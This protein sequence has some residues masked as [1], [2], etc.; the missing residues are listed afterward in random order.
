M[1]IIFYIYIY[2]ECVF[3]IL[4]RICIYTY[5][6]YVYKNMYISNNMYI[7]IHIYIYIYIYI[8]L[9]GFRSAFAALLSQQEVVARLR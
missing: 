7:H 2:I 8:Y 5:I 1:Y 9:R 6:E 4:Y 3:Y